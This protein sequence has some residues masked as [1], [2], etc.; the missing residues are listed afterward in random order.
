[1]TAARGAGSEASNSQMTESAVR[2]LNEVLTMR[3]LLGLGRHYFVFALSY[4][5]RVRLDLQVENAH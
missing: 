2:D 4:S 5:L 1:M 3:L